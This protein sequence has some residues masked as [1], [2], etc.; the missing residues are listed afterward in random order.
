[1]SNPSLWP[2]AELQLFKKRRQLSEQTQTG[3]TFLPDTHQLHTSTCSQSACVNQLHGSLRPQ[4]GATDTDTLAAAGWQ[5]PVPELLS[6][7]VLWAETGR[8][9]GRRPPVGHT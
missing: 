7:L 6:A 1:M 2:P 3:G 5:R 9:K 8:E 4:D